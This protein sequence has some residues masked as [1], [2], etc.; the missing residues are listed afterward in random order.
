MERFKQFAQSGLMKG[1]KLGAQQV[2]FFVMKNK[3]LDLHV[4]DNRVDE[5]TM[6][7]NQ[8][9]GVRVIKDHQLGFSFSTDFSSTA[10][11]KMLSQAI[12]NAKYNDRDDQLVF[13]EK[14]KGYAQFDL[15]DQATFAVPMKEKIELAKETTDIA[16]KSHRKVEKVVYSSYQDEESE[17]WL[18]NSNGLLAYQKGSACGLY[19]VALGGEGTEQQ[20]GYG[21]D[22][23][24]KYAGLSAKK[25]GEMAGVKAVRLLG[26]LPMSSKVADII[27]EPLVAIQILG[28][29]ATGFSGEGVLKGKSMFANKMN[30]Q[31]A[32][33]LV[34]LV[35]DGTL[36]ERL[37]TTPFD[38]EG[39]P[40]SRTMLVENGILKS[41][42]YDTYNANKAGTLSTG[43]GMRGSYKGTPGIGTTNYYLEGG[44]I[45]PE[46]LLMQVDQGLYVTEIL[47]A[48]TANPISGDFSFGASGL[49]VENGKFIKPIRGVTIAGNFK[50]LLM[51]IEM[52]AD[53]LTFF[54]SSGSPTIKIAKVN[55]SGT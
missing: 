39:V 37:G 29:I 21:A 10:L 13:P 33:P 25:A 6:A 27:L 34:S 45:S 20:S 2:E 41:Y 22:F 50:T 4:K 14:A 32:G 1:K 24:L 53:D 35:D 11:D 9:I 40:T 19:C 18:A 46:A 16:L 23:G 38:G 55:I 3:A 7:E 31:I 44:S 48:H 54:G 8:G 26:A 30:Q 28:I 36:A 47:G 42:L 49:W 52:V 15:Y 12:A 43:N 5:L 17:V 51:D